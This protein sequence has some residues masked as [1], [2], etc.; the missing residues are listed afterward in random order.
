MKNIL[1]RSNNVLI[2]FRIGKT[3]N[4]KI[5]LSS[6]NIVQT[7]SF[8][9]E[10][11][12]IAKGKTDMKTFFAADGSVCM[13]CPFSVSNGAKLSA[14]Y[15]HKMMQYS[16]F[17]SMLRGI[18][19]THLE[20]VNIPTLDSN[21]AA[22]IVEV[23]SNKYV[24][25]GTYGEPSLIDVNLVSSIVSVSKSHTGYTHQ[26]MKKSEYAPF[27]MASVHNAFGES[28]AAKIGYRSFIAAKQSDTKFISCPASN[29]MGFKSNCSKC[30]LCSG[31]RKGKKSIIILEH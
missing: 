20:W 25:F 28:M 21:I 19:K 26:W 7:Y 13:D 4:K 27:F 11:Y 17:L 18:H 2:V 9:K 22:K 10:Q 3:S 8:S 23:S 30:G 29:E 5:A 14:C 16:G 24:R 6:E 12:E 15:T 31:A 1:F